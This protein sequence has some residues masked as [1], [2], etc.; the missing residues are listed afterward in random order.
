MTQG[1]KAMTH[2]STAF[3]KKVLERLIAGEGQ[4]VIA[5]DLKMSPKTVWN[6]YDLYTKGKLGADGKPT[7]E[8]KKP[9]EYKQGTRRIPGE[10]SKDVPVAAKAKKRAHRKIEKKVAQKPQRS[11][12]QT[13]RVLVIA[14]VQI[15]RLERE[16]AFVKADR[17]ILVKAL[18]SLT[19]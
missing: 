19:R 13:P 15:Q 10:A 8:K 4:S 18:S 1:K 2:F 9:L 11:D 16:L 12:G 17:D 14:Q 6:W 5:D 7:D 3:K